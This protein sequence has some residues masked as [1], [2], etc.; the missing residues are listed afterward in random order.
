VKAQ[1]FLE[2]VLSQPLKQI[3]AD[4]PIAHD[5]LA[6]LRLTHLNPDLPLA[7]SLEQATDQALAEFCLDRDMIVRDFCHFLDVFCGVQAASPRIRTLTVQGGVDKSGTRECGDFQASIGDIVSI[8]GPTGSGKSRLLADI[9]C[10]AAGD[11]PTG[12]HI[13]VDG[14]VLSDEDRYGM[15][16]RL[17][18]Q[19]S[20]NM[21]FVMDVTVREFLE[22]H[23]GSRL[24]QDVGRTVEQCFTCANQLTGEKFHLS[25]KVTQLS[26]GQSRA[27]MIADTA[28]MSASPIVLIDEIEN[29]GID[30]R[31]AV[32][33]LARKEKIVFLATHD[34]LL[35]LSAA[36]RLVIRNGG[37]VKVL[38]TSPEEKK[39]LAAIEKLD[40]TMFR[41]RQALRYG[42]GISR[43]TMDSEEDDHVGIV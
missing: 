37:I 10:L 2:L 16:G 12:R 18:A 23:A 35:A 19:L 20:Q 28:F 9:E 27:L 33:I 43:E 32:D 31:R 15:E 13:L 1:Q 36:R 14:R 24:A 21:N 40:A 25:T 3:L 17:V 22:M 29:A 8:V 6:N 38:T 11:T 7:R 41:L 42:H 34:P 26:G 39:C 4:H 30:R 5:F